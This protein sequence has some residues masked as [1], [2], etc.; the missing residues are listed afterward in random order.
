MPPS[1]RLPRFRLTPMVPR[2]PHEPHRVAS[3]LEL[4]FDLVF[5][6]AVSIAGQH[7]HHS[8]AEGHVLHGVESFAMVFLTIWWAWMNFTWFAT[9]F[10]TDDWLYRVLTIA[11]MGGVLILA[12]GIG[13]VFEHG[14]FRV[15]VWGY[16]VMRIALVLQWLRASRCG[17]AAGRAARHYAAGVFCVQVLWNLWVWL[18]PEGPLRVALFVLLV[19]LELATPVLAETRGRTPWH[20][21]HITERYG[22]FT[23]IVLGESLLGSANA[24]IEG[25]HDPTAH[26]VGDL[27]QMAVLALLVTAGMWWIYFWGPHH[28]AITTFAKSLRY[29]YV[30]YVVFAAAGAVSAGIEV[31]IDQLSG[32]TEISDAA[33]GYTLAVPVALF[34]MGTWWLTIRDHAPRPVNVLVPLGALLILVDPLLPTPVGATAVLV[35][36]VVV[37]LVVW[38]PLPEAQEPERPALAE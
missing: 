11:Q 16:V 38:S 37:V 12:A 33:A 10:D 1:S 25:L 36:L 5:V 13:P 35:V 17:G 26:G 31:Q 34:I 4:F 6:V 2:N 8:I 32:H 23:L 18:A 9:S 20:P 30:H 3:S 22:L 7:L 24:I 19:L 29:G 15:V 14:E 28:R 21:H 27:E